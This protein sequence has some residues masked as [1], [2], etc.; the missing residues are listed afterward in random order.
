[1]FNRIYAQI[2]VDN[3]RYN[4][5]SIMARHKKDMKLLAVIKADAYG[6]GS[7]EIAQRIDDLAYYYGV[8]AIDEAVELRNAGIKK[9]ILI[10]GYTSPEDYDKL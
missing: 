8:A 5:K 3:L 2:N 4:I 9:P 1:M 7:C 6:H 10:I